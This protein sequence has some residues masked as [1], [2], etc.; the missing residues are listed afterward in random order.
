MRITKTYSEG[1]I[2]LAP[3]GEIDMASVGQVRDAII[4]ALAQEKPPAIVLDFKDVPLIDSTGMGELVRCHRAAA[5]SGTVLT[6]ENLAPLPRRQ[7]WATGLLGLFGLAAP[8]P[9]KA[10]RAEDEV[11]VPEIERSA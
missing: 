3:F 2:R 8:Q 5:V 7:L 11:F 10:P 9:G 1:G 4:A 6:L